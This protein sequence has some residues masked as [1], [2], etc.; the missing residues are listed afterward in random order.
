MGEL[1]P[2]SPGELGALPDEQLIDRAMDEFRELARMAGDGVVDPQDVL[3]QLLDPRH[4][5]APQEGPDG[6]SIEP[7]PDTVARV[8]ALERVVTEITL[9]AGFM[10]SFFGSDEAQQIRRE[11]ADG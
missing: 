6:E 10:R 7:A 5:L 11:Q 2:P 8:E 3:A 1:L 4:Y 9:R